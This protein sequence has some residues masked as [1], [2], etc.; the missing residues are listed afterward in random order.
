L[1]IEQRGLRKKIFKFMDSYV[2]RHGEEASYE[3]IALALTNE[4]TVYSAG[5]IEDL[6]HLYEARRVVSAD[7]RLDDDGDS[8]LDFIS[9]SGE[10]S[11]LSRLYRADLRKII[12]SVLD[13]L[14]TSSPD[15][16]RILDLF[17][18]QGTPFK[19]IPGKIKR[20]RNWVRNQL[21]KGRRDLSNII[22]RNPVYQ[23]LKAYNLI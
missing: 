22:A 3:Q 14:R 16:A 4:T 1:S 19:E 5:Q 18:L 13:E 2:M 9:V 15:E 12:N 17:Y 8:L 21:V 6:L 10:H 7:K 23:E 11:I 20:E